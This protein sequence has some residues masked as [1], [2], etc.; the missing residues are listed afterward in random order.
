MYI[1]RGVTG[2]CGEKKDVS[3]LIQQY[4]WLTL[5]TMIILVYIDSSDKPQSRFYAFLPP[6]Y[7]ISDERELIKFRIKKQN[8]C[9]C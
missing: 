2:L 8:T 6:F 1:Y 3:Y 4:L 9:L 5:L 7:F